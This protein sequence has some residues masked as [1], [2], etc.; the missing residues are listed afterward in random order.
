MRH[1]LLVPLAACWTSS[2]TP[3]P[4]T[5]T[6]TEAPATS[7]AWHDTAEPEP[8]PEVALTCAHPTKWLVFDFESPNASGRELSKA[9]R[10]AAAADSC[11]Q[12]I[13]PGVSF[14]DAK[15]ANQCASEHTACMFAIGAQWGADVMVY[16]RIDTTTTQAIVRRMTIT[17]RSNLLVSV[18]LHANIADDGRVLFAKLK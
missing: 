7:R 11:V 4:A 1:L 15:L 2:T 12:V 9:L 6:E 16:G 17:S 18:T 14:A 13:K 3:P 5:P 10:T 8:K